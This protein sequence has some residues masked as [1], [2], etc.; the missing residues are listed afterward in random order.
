MIGKNESAFIE[1]NFHNISNNLCYDTH[2]IYVDSNSTDNSILIAEKY[3]IKPNNITIVRIN[4]RNKINAAIA[5][6]YG[7]AKVRDDASYVLFL[8]GDMVLNLDFIKNSIAELEKSKE[9]AACTG[10]FNNIYYSDLE[11]TI[12]L[13]KEETKFKNRI[14]PIKAMGGN[15]I[16]KKCI[17]QQI[18]KFDENL[19]INEDID[20][21]FRIRNLKY[22]V[23]FIPCMLGEH[24]TV[25]YNNL[26]RIIKDFKTKKYISV[27]LMIQKYLLTTRS[28]DLLRPLRHVLLNL[29]LFIILF[30][31]LINTYFLY[32]FIVIF[33]IKYM[34]NI[35][36]ISILEQFLSLF[37]S[38]HVVYG[39]LSFRKNIK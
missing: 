2:I 18:G 9:L 30:L 16:I 10:Y 17:L 38:I 26:K 27:G 32:T 5:R 15:F 14:R 11:K 35:N 39:F 1:K 23:L 37:F 24:N 7:I 8:D 3:Q 31:S 13:R 4:D 29:F 25:L 22:K 33:L 34:K 19:T 12:F 6:N 21:C 28:V 36:R 20:Y